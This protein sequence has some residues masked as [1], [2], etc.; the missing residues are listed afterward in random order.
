MNE[1]E[2]RVK[3]A[4]IKARRAI[5]Q[6]CKAIRVG[7]MEVDNEFQTRYKP[8]IEP[9]KEIAAVSGAFP[10]ETKRKEFKQSQITPTK[11]T[12]LQ[13]VKNKATFSESESDLDIEKLHERSKINRVPDFQPAHVVAESSDHENSQVGSPDVDK[14]I[15]ALRDTLNSSVIDDFLEQYHPLPRQYLEE[16]IRDTNNACDTTYGV[17]YDVETDR[18]QIGDSYIEI[19]GKDL[20]IKERKYLGTPGLYELLFKVTPIGYRDSDLQQYREILTLTNAHKKNF[21]PDSQIAGNRGVKYKQI[22]KPLFVQPK[23]RTKF[24]SKSTTSTGWGIYTP[25]KHVNDGKVEYIYW[26]RPSELIARLRLLHASQLAGNNS[27]GNRNEILSIIEE[28]Q[29]EGIIE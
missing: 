14:N 20:L 27:V 19:E 13:L 18:W 16:L 25:L 1:H 4:I 21:N 7:R 26:N 15:A 12:K 5:Q 10:S 11:K 3:R 8:I 22:I 24:R 17:R 6:K 23:E 9:L 29:E 28:L 2:Q